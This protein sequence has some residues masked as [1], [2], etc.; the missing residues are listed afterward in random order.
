MSS[1]APGIPVDMGPKKKKGQLRGKEGLKNA[2]QLAQYSTQSLGR[3]DSVRRGEPE[4]KIKGK[5][6]SFRDNMNSTSSSGNEKV[7]K[8]GRGLIYTVLTYRLH[9]IYIV[10]YCVPYRPL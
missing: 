6:R 10:L 2:L 7:R 4:K 8:E 1:S 5:K 9:T 3:F